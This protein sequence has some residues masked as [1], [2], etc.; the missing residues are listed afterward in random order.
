V[1]KTETINGTTTAWEYIYD[2]AGRLSQTNQNGSLWASYSY[3]ANGNRLAKTT[4]SQTI[5]ASYDAQ[6]RMLSYGNNTYSYSANGELL[7]KTNTATGEVTS[8][9]YDVLGNL[10][11]VVLPDSTLIEYVVDGR[12]RRVGKK[13]NGTLQRAWLYDGQLRPVA[14]LDGA[15]NLTAR[16]V[17]ATH[18]NVPDYVIK[19]ATTYRVITDQLGSLRFVIDAS[20]GV[21]AQRMDYDDW[22]N[23]LANTNPDFTPFGF[24]GGLYDYQTKLVRFGARDYDAESG[25]WTSKD[26]IGLA[27]NLSVYSYAN[28][29]PT[30]LLDPSGLVPISDC[31]KK[32]LQ[33]YFPN[34]DLSKVRLNSFEDTPLP[35]KIPF[36]QGADAW[37]LGNDIFFNQGEL[38]QSSAIGIALIGHELTHVQQYASLG[39]GFPEIGVGPFI[40]AYFP[41]IGWNMLKG[42]NADEAYRKSY[43]EAPAFGM[44]DRILADLGGPNAKNPCMCP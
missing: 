1:T 35:L 16:F 24:A 10:K 31:V 5:P 19:G 11:K 23:V 14:E 17:Y 13:V 34:L 3:D 27:G 36:V 40:N 2:A 22:G 7:A 4:S 18:I 15:G 12:N 25:R 39:F 43:F 32:L 38:D 29:I 30:N 26:P 42:M 21:V 37:T 9:T 28:N 41:A 44:Y 33:K 8:Y 20:T 6:D